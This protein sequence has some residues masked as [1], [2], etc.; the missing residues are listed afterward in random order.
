[1]GM[2]LS[3]VPVKLYIVSQMWSAY[4]FTKLQ[5]Y[6]ILRQWYVQE[7]HK[8]MFLF[9]KLINVFPFEVSRSVITVQHKFLAQFKKYFILVWC[10]FFKPYTKLTLHCY[11]RTGHLKTEQTECLLLLRCHLGNWSCGPAGSITSNCW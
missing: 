11:H 8:I 5:F 4:F 9:Q 7:T 6:Y 10:A 1:M 3:I 2:Q